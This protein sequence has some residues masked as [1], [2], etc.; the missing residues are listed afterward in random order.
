MNYLKNY[1]KVK[2]KEYNFGTYTYV[3]DIWMK[4]ILKKINKKQGP[5]IYKILLYMWTCLRK[6]ITFVIFEEQKSCD[7][8]SSN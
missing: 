5:M 8:R 7:I 4:R 6:K 3:T 2:I 1:T